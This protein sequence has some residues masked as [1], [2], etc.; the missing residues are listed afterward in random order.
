[1]LRILGLIIVSTALSWGKYRLQNIIGSVYGRHFHGDHHHH[2]QL[3]QS[4]RAPTGNFS[5][6]AGVNAVLSQLQLVCTQK[7][8]FRALNLDIECPP[9][10]PELT[11]CQCLTK[12]KDGD[13]ISKVDGKISFD[14]KCG[15]EKIRDTRSSVTGHVITRSTCCTNIRNKQTLTGSPLIAATVA[16]T[17]AQLVLCPSE[18][19]YKTKYRS[20]AGVVRCGDRRLVGRCLCLDT[21]RSQR[22]VGVVVGD[23]CT[24][25]KSRSGGGNQIVVRAVCCSDQQKDEAGEVVYTQ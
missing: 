9:S 11:Q 19:P 14:S 13:L 24:C 23:Q 17:S 16:E 6:T 22:R 5:L 20:T 7:K 15:C 12:D 18:A 4:D 25:K 21:G 1:M 8:Q 2:S 3:L 10:L